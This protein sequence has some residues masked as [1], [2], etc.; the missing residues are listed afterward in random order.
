MLAHPTTSP[1]SNMPP[2]R[3]AQPTESRP[4][5]AIALEQKLLARFGDVL[6][7]G[8][9]GSAC[10][11][12]P[13]VLAA[14]E[15]GPFWHTLFATL[16]FSLRVAD[17]RRAEASGAAREGI[18]TIPSESVCFPAKL[19]HMRLHDL[20]RQGV[21][22]VFM[23]RYARG[24]RCPVTSLYAS[25]LADSVPL[26]RDGACQLASPEPLHHEAVRP[27]RQRP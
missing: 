26:L 10:I 1:A 13:G 6:P 20:A 11:G 7:G 23:P 14:Y 5:N 9:R 17:D 2:A 12:L 4:P 15:Q 25:A 22:A 16:G 24:N 3:A 27:L 18:G 19:A 8:Q 21:A